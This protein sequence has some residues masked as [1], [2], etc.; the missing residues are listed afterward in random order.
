[1]FSCSLKYRL[2]LFWGVV[3]INKHESIWANSRLRIMQ[4]KLVQPY[5]VLHI[6]CF[7]KWRVF[8]FFLKNVALRFAFVCP[9]VVVAKVPPKGR[10][11]CAGKSHSC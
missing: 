7:E 4:S 2:M 8:F 1:M 9:V 5:V 3:A 10:S 11:H 6:G